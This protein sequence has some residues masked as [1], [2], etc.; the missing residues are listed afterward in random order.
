M[1]Q[2]VKFKNRTWD[3]AGNI[4][5][6]ADFD[7]S[8]KYAAI[9]CVHPGSS[10]KEQTAGIYA[11]KLAAEGFIALAFDASFQGESGGE[12]RFIEDPAVRVED[13]RAAVDFLTT[14]DYVDENRIGVLGICAGG[15]YAVNAAMTE[16]R[17]KAV[18]TV[19]GANIGRLY[20]EGNPVQTLT[21]VGQQ[22]TAEARGT[23]PMITNWIPNSPEE[24]QKAGVTDIDVV[25]AVDYYRTPRGQQPTAC[26]MLRFTSLANVMAFDAFHLVEQLLTQP[27]QIIAGSVPG[28]FGSLNDAKELFARV[29]GKKDLHIAEGATHY[30]MY[31]KPERVAEAVSKLAPFYKENL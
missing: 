2:A 14:F 12:P 13:V 20:R 22:R 10:V 9:I 25:E 19:V 7:A 3:V 28:A 6:P 4:H 15:G 5:I 16:H 23:E 24:A 8:K 17:I 18:G 31:D 27:I 30:D 21:A 26:N 1:T 29:K 11:G